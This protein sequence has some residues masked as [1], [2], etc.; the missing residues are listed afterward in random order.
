M[1]MPSI[2]RPLYWLGLILAFVAAF[3]GLGAVLG[4]AVYALWA[5][6]NPPADGDLAG[7]VLHGMSNGARWFGVW[8]GGLGFILAFVK[9]HHGFTLRAW[10][11][12]RLSP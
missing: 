12:A 5:S 2:P 11:R 1:S 8:A 3:C 4:G 10:L 6:V 9:A 7:F